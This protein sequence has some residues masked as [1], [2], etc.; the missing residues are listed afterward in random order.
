M[1]V[2][3]VVEGEADDGVGVLYGNLQRDVVDRSLVVELLRDLRELFG[4]F[5][6][7]VDFEDV[8]CRVARKLVE[9]VA[10]VVHIDHVRA[11]HAD[12]IGR[13]VVSA[14]E[15]VHNP[16]I[17]R[18]EVFAARIEVGKRDGA[19][20]EAVGEGH[21]RDVDEVLRHLGFGQA[22]EA[23]V[24]GVIEDGAVLHDETVDEALEVMLGLLV[25]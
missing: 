24:D 22:V 12:G 9:V 13:N 17:D 20:V 23:R 7:V 11:T 2:V 6:H 1:W 25:E 18:R 14:D 10:E 16:R 15:F 5:V 3:H 8:M 19:L 4:G 21:H